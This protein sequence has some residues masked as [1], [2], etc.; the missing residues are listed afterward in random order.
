MRLPTKRF[1]NSLPAQVCRCRVHVKPS[2]T[3]YSGLGPDNRVLVRKARKKA[4][5]YYQY[6]KE[7]IPAS[8]LVKEIAA[9]MQE[10][11]QS[12]GVRPFGVSLLYAGFDDDGPHLY[13]IDPSGAYFAWKATAIGKDSVNAKTFLERVREKRMAGM[14]FSAS[15]TRWNSKMPFTPLY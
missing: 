3:V 11:T 9:T 1:P 7:N 14:T 5:A 8:M 4:Q 10:F 2:G 6:Y 15:T 12:G 13:Q